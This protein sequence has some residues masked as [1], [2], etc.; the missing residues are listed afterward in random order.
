MNLLNTLRFIKGYVDFEIN[1]GF[2]ERFINLCA[3]NRIKIWNV[4]IKNGSLYA[5]ISANN[6]GSLRTVLRKSGCRLHIIKKVGLPFFFHKNKHRK[7]LII[8]AVCFLLFIFL[9]NN[10][11]WLIEVKGT[12]TLSFE[13]I[14]NTVMQFGLRRGV[15]SPSLNTTEISRN[16]VNYFNGRLI[17]MSINIKGSKAVIEV[18]DY[19]DEHEDKTFKDPCNIVADFD[20]ELLSVEVYNGD[21]EVCVGNAVKKGDMLISGV[22]ENEDL[23]CVYSEARG[24]ITALHNINFEKI[25]ERKLSKTERISNYKTK[26]KLIFFEKDIPLFIPTLINEE[27][28]IYYRKYIFSGGYKLPFGIEKTLFYENEETTED[29][30]LLFA[31]DN[32][33][34]SYYSEFK[35]TNIINSKQN[36]TVNENT[37]IISSDLKCI[38]FIGVKS[39]IYVDFYEK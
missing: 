13:E 27:R 39:P 7:G 8:S 18:R 9:M 11:V 37:Y 12:E 28:D 6:F 29:C 1:G 38:D 24:K 5:S 19:I 36:V 23:S 22:I 4:Q 33:A 31:L 21:K 2:V 16:A 32:Y 26:F 15:Y 35:N 3:V 20:G 30:S 25:Y 14:E 34:S 17:W 10:F